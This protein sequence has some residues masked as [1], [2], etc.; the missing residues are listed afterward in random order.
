MKL[1]R[2]VPDG[3]KF[4]FVR[5]R[6]VSFPFS[7]ICSLIT[8]VL[9]LT[10]GLNFGIDFKGGTLIELQAKTG[11]A[12]VGALRHTLQGFVVGEVEAQEFGGG[13]GVSL[14]Y[15]A[16]PGG[17]QAQSDAVKKA[18]EALDPTYEFRRVETV[19]PRVSGE[20]VQTG[21][22]GV[23]L[24]ILAVLVYLWFRFEM[25]FAIGAIIGT[26]HDIVLTIGFFLI[27]RT[28]FNMTSIAAILTIVGYSLNETV[29]VFDRT[30][31]L[32]RRYRRMPMAE[33]LDL[34]VNSTLARTSMTATTAA[35][36]LL[37]LVVFGGQAIEDFAKVMLCGVIVATYSAIFI[38]SPSLIYLG[39]HGKTDAEL[40]AEEKGGAVAA[41]AAAPKPAA[42]KPSATKPSAAKPS[43]AKPTAAKPGR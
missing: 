5:F 39:V 10:V 20:L 19:G 17:E 43:A 33:L 12:D 4:R 21:T 9:F 18:H 26:M 28:E 34:S 23:V 38:S 24:A 41:R 22:I 11:K 35:L 6:R 14:R 36:S 2:I 32:L 8:V 30:R 1:L 37:A 15:Q 7:A 31:E 27:T 13:E 3:T 40:A 29:V 16:Q 25:Q 42:A